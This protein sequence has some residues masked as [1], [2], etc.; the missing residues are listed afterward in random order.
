MLAMPLDRIHVESTDGT[1][2]RMANSYRGLQFHGEV[3]KAPDKARL[4][5]LLLAAVAELDADHQATV[6]A[7]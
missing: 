2:V 7:L 3:D 4:R 6:G 1:Y 5:S